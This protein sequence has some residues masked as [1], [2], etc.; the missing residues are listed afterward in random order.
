MC[1][2]PF[3]IILVSFFL[4]SSIV[5]TVYIKEVSADNLLEEQAITYFNKAK[6]LERKGDVEGAIE[7]YQK[8]ILLDKSNIDIYNQ[9]GVLY[10]K[11]GLPERAEAMYLKAISKNPLCL[12]AHNNL[13]YLYE[14]QGEINKA[15]THWRIRIALADSD[16]KWVDEVRKKLSKY[17]TSIVDLEKS[18]KASKEKTVATD[19]LDKVE[20]SNQHVLEGRIYLQQKDFQ[21]A[22]TEFEKAYKLNPS[23]EIGNYIRK[24]EGFL[25]ARDYIKKGEKF[26]INNNYEQAM[27]N[28]NQAQSLLPE[29]SILTELTKRVKFEL[30]LNKANELFNQEQY[31]E[32]L[33]IV[34]K[35]VDLEPDNSLANSLKNKIEEILI[36]Q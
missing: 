32:A 28:F 19:L 24:T 25:K 11:K 20:E 1:K 17:D 6:E 10:E 35:A 12:P 30:Y 33:G 13:A 5:F 7:F 23:S 2:I 29:N 4:I 31:E 8:S 21:S 15:V 27:Y 18:I 9:L 14:S 34:N 22:L 36:V 16:D 3:K 26:Y